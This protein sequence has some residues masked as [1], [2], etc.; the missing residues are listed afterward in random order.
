MSL[1]FVKRDIKN[2]NITVFSDGRVMSGD[3]LFVDNEH[4]CKVSKI[5]EHCL[6]GVCG[7]SLFRDKITMAFIDKFDF[8]LFNNSDIFIKK[9]IISKFVEEQ[10]LLYKEEKLNEEDYPQFTSIIVINDEIYVCE[11]FANGISTDLISENTYAVGLGEK[12]ARILL[13]CDFEAQLI[14][15][16]MS[17]FYVGINNKLYWK[18]IDF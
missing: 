6:I 13:D 11:R 3:R 16:K 1:V 14:L 17:K 5:N 15:D 4:F 7:S 9:M 10:M 12:T 18:T 2:R 8:N